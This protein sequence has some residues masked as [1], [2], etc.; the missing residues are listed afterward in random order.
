MDNRFRDCKKITLDTSHTICIP[1]DWSFEETD[2]IYRIYDQENNLWA[3]GTNFG[4]ECDRFAD[5]SEFF[6]TFVPLQ[7]IYVTHESYPPISFMAGANISKKHVHGTDGS[8]SYFYIYLM[9]ITS[10]AD[11]CFVL[12][13]DIDQD[14]QSFNVAEALMY[15]FAW[16]NKTKCAQIT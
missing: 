13:D 11:T 1:E 6:S 2:G 12:M 15:S 5:S 16:P 7:D 9:D 8:A 3:M 4:T 10:G 14:A